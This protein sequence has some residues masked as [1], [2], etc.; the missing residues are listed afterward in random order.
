MS[1]STARPAYM[2][3]PLGWVSYGDMLAIYNANLSYCNAA[4]ALQEVFFGWSA[5]PLDWGGLI[6]SFIPL[7]PP[8][9]SAVEVSSQRETVTALHISLQFPSFK[10]A[11]YYYPSRIHTTYH[12]AHTNT[13]RSFKRRRR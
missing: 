9:R 13:R 5:L 4:A 8:L 10:K 6:S 12:K 2:P 1:T 7:T 11:T 3:R